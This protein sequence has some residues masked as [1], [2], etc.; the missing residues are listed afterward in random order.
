MKTDTLKLKIAVLAVSSIVA[1]NSVAENHRFIA[2]MMDE[3]KKAFTDTFAIVDD[4]TE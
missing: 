1:G 4:F 2:S 3:V